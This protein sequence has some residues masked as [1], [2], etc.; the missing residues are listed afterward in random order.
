MHLGKK[1]EKAAK[2][3]VKTVNGAKNLNNAEKNG[4]DI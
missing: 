3:I 4:I 1:C 2:T